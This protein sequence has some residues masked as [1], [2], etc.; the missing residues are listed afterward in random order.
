MKENLEKIS[1][2]L[3]GVGILIAIYG[4]YKIY[5]TTA[6]LPQGSCP[7][8]DNRPVMFVAIGALMMSLILSFVSDIINKANKNKEQ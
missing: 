6:Y 8:E 1:T 5:S 7:I 3:M 2:Y 4:G